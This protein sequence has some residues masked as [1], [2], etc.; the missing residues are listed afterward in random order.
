MYLSVKQ[1]RLSL[2]SIK[3]S[4]KKY[5]KLLSAPK[6]SKVYREVTS[7][8]QGIYKHKIGN[9]LELRKKFEKEIRS[10]GYRVNI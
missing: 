9:L 1:L 8:F 5:E 4:I 10:R 6:S 7:E 3:D 2:R